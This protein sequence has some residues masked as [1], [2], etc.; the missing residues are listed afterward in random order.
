VSAPKSVHGQVQVTQKEHQT[1]IQTFDKH[2]ILEYQ[3]FD[4]DKS[5]T[6]RFIVPDAESKVL[7]RIISPL[8]SH[9]D[10]RIESNGILYFI[11]PH[12]LIFGKNAT[13]S[14]SQFFAG[15]ASLSNKD[16]LN[17]LDSFSN[18]QG[19]LEHW[20]AIKAEK[21]HLIA[22]DI[23]QNGHIV[24]NGGFISMTSSNDVII[25]NEDGGVTL[26]LDP[27]SYESVNE[28]AID[29]FM[30]A[31]LVKIYAA[32]LYGALIHIKEHAKTQV[33]ALELNAKAVDMSKGEVKID[34]GLAIDKLKVVADKSYLKG[35]HQLCGNTLI[36]AS[37]VELIAD[38]NFTDSG[39]IIF[40]Q[41]VF[42]EPNQFWALTLDAGGAITVQ[43]SAG[44][45]SSK[46]LGELN[47]LN[48]TDLSLLGSV[49]AHKVDQQNGS[50]NTHIVGP[51][52]T[53]IPLSFGGD[54]KIKTSGNVT[55]DQTID[56]R[57][58][59]AAAGAG[60]GKVEIRSNGSVIV[61]DIFTNGNA[62]P[63]TFPF[64][65]GNAGD[66]II[67]DNI[68]ME[69]TD[70]ISFT[71]LGTI[72]LYGVIFATG[73]NALI[74]GISGEVKISKNRKQFPDIATV[75]SNPAGSDLEIRA[76]K[77][78]FHENSVVTSF[79][80]LV[81]IAD[82][83]LIIS[84]LIAVD[85]VVFSAPQVDVLSHPIGLICLANGASFP[86]QLVHISAGGV[87]TGG[88]TITGLENIPVIINAFNFDTVGK[89]KLRSI[90]TFNNKPLNFN[91]L[92]LQSLILTTPHYL[93]H[94][95][96]LQPNYKKMTQFILKDG[97]SIDALAAHIDMLVY[98]LDPG[99]V[100][101]WEKIRDAVLKQNPLNQVVGVY[102]NRIR[103]GTFSPPIFIERL[104]FSKKG[105]DA[106]TYLYQVLTL[107]TALLKHYT[108]L[109]DEA[110]DLITL[111]TLPQAL[112]M[113]DWERVNRVIE[114]KK[115][116][117]SLN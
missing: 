21:V 76:R 104:K 13:L 41:N 90:L 114:T 56:T 30:E 70:K 34:V 50:A 33:S 40:E 12:G 48:C 101:T 112:S 9:I 31:Q 18:I 58:D 14:A 8:P 47:V 35:S 22:K 3:K 91:P 7:N 39:D 61:H 73:G 59:S 87:V 62:N 52:F 86:S 63:D 81:L 68:E 29:G 51:V 77:I 20:G 38:T 17:G 19:R 75:F 45:D 72:G 5:Q 80:N 74:K 65:G 23:F 53:S 116:F 57:G 10:G 43:G 46:A 95:Y 55:I 92:A 25:S 4:L 66:V 111:F 2:T 97:P 103:T 117:P 94:P 54:F 28:I 115:A 105:R 24:T 88:S 32:D 96:H 79:G 37:D 36:F 100:Q 60:G 26:R 11:N 49:F 27:S 89:S 83:H 113:E 64:F 99:L 85:N 108:P 71:P 82:E 67:E 84:D 16:F 110:V 69:V 106:L 1:S 107:K 15:C 42:S 78:Q 102:L 6:V 109:S 44:V 98:Y 93:I